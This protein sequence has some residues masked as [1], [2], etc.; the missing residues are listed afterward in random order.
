MLGVAGDDRR[1]MGQRS[2]GDHQVRAVMAKIGGQPSPD[3]RIFCA[4]GQ[5]AVR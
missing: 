1:A 2:G 5:D 4:K 3:P